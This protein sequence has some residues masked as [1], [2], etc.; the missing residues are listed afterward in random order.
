[1]DPL[2]TFPPIHVCRYRSHT[3]GLLHHPV[4][5]GVGEDAE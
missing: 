2:L 5:G 3:G 4:H 1:M